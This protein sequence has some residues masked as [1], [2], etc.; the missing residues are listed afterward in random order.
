VIPRVPQ[1]SRHV[2]LQALAIPGKIPPKFLLDCPA[3]TGRSITM[4]DFYASPIA[5]SNAA[6]IKIDKLRYSLCD[7]AS[8]EID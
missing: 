7:S 2:D 6:V 8:V 4:N 3:D 1:I 5:A